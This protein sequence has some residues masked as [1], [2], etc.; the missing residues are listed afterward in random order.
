M[1]NVASVGLSSNDE[2]GSPNVGCSSWQLVPLHWTIRCC[3]CRVNVWE[4][5]RNAA[6][7]GDEAMRRRL[8]NTE[9]RWFFESVGVLRPSRTPRPCWR[10]TKRRNVASLFQAMQRPRTSWSPPARAAVLHISPL[11]S[12]RPPTFQPRLVSGGVTAPDGRHFEPLVAT[13]C[14][15]AFLLPPVGCFLCWFQIMWS[16]FEYREKCSL[17]KMCYYSS[18]NSTPM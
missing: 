8:S 15:C 9:R 16:V 2:G 6:G 4:M 11:P 3:C 1:R 13:C 12:V 14:C 5:V 17:N 7:G 18:V 10:E